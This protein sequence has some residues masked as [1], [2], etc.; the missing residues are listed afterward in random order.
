MVLSGVIGSG[1]IL[2]TGGGGKW[3]QLGTLFLPGFGLL[4][5][6]QEEEILVPVV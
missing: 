1:A 2:S 5:L 4:M 3:F 6:I